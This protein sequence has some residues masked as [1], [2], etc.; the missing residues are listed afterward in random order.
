MRHYYLRSFFV[1]LSSCRSFL[2]PCAFLPGPPSQSQGPCSSLPPQQPM[3]TGAPPLHSSPHTETR[4]FPAAR[5]PLHTTLRSV[6][7]DLKLRRMQ[8]RAPCGVC[9][10]LMSPGLKVGR[11]AGGEAGNSA[12]GRKVRLWQMILEVVRRKPRIDVFWSCVMNDF[13]NVRK[14]NTR[15]NLLSTWAKAQKGP[16]GQLPHCCMSLHLVDL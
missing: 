15:G 5:V 13:W 7:R 11:G 3:A 1:K 2:P 16:L 6:R 9:W 8:T 4:R 10:G 14:T 12:W